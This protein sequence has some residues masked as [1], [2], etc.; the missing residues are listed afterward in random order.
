MRDLAVMASRNVR[1]VVALGLVAL[2]SVAL[3]APHLN[4]MG[5]NPSPTPSARPSP[6]ASPSATQAAG[7]TSES[8]VV[9]GSAGFPVSV[10]GQRVYP[11][12]GG[13]RSLTGS[14]LLAAGA[15]SGLPFCP[16]ATFESQ[17][18]ADLL[19]CSV[20][21]YPTYSFAVGFRTAPKSAGFGGWGGH[22]IVVRA[23]THDPEATQ[24]SADRRADCE[25]ALVVEAVAWPAVPDEIDG[26]HVYRAAEGRTL[27]GSATSF[28]IGG[29][30]WVETRDRPFPVCSRSADRALDPICGS[31]VIDVDGTATAPNTLLRLLD[32]RVVVVRAHFDA[33]LAAQ[34]S[35]DRIPDCR[36]AIVVESIVW[37]SDPYRKS[38]AVAPSPNAAATPGRGRFALTGSMSVARGGHTA[39]LL[40]DGRVLV[41][42]GSWDGSAELY[43]PATGAF[44]PTGRLNAIRTAGATATLL[45][46]GRV[47]VAGG[48]DDSAAQQPLASAELYDPRTGTF[49]P[50]GS[51]AKARSGQSATLLSDGRVLIA[52]GFDSAGGVLSSAEL[53][54]PMT[55]MFTPTGPMARARSEQTATLLRDGRVLLVGG[56]NGLTVPDSAASSAELYEP[57]TGKFVPTGSPGT[58]RSAGHTATLLPDGR[59]LVAGGNTSGWQERP[60]GTAEVYDPTTGRFV[61]TRSMHD[62][63]D[64]ATATLLEDGRVLVVGGDVRTTE[65]YDPATGGFSST[66]STVYPRASQSATLLAD[67]RVLIVA[68]ADDPYGA[69]AELYQ[70]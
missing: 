52:G 51:M 43:D 37:S 26:E 35:A 62:A 23:H 21:I 14:F 17:A 36:S 55:G 65:L 5:P 33:S 28:L 29:V 10:D 63:R 53:Y 22:I 7:P 50:T 8:T 67:G 41:A 2:V 45:P 40:Q 31:A 58:S 18:E 69:T 44:G 32:S 57:G 1:W 13:W 66:G 47:L 49:M 34:C 59:V 9:M 3:L 61:T 39:T 70:P 6:S 25:A 56:S 30:V 4:L 12:E 24:C 11:F 54:D 64:G 60:I 16:A 15:G 27:A 20:P 19:G 42:G 38:S 48:S 68:G 46:D